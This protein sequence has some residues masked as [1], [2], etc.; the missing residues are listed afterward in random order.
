MSEH[1]RKRKRSVS[2]SSV[3]TST[4]V[5]VADM[6]YK[7]AKPEGLRQNKGLSVKTTGRETSSCLPV[8]STLDTKECSIPGEFEHVDRKHKRKELSLSTAFLSQQKVSP[9]DISA[10]NVTEKLEK[11]VENSRNDPYYTSGQGKHAP[12][13]LYVLQTHD[14]K[15]TY[16]GIANN[17]RRRMGSHNYC[18]THSNAYTA[19][20]GRPWSVVATVKGFETRDIAEQF[21]KLV[22]TYPCESLHHVSAVDNRVYR[23]LQ[24]C[25]ALIWDPL[26]IEV[27]SGVNLTCL[28][29]FPLP[30]YC[31]VERVKWMNPFNAYI[32]KLKRQGWLNMCKQEGWE[33]DGSPSG[34]KSSLKQ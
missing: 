2:P 32:H 20:R 12:V 22:K 18:E 14:K 27:D 17:L 26:L 4:S 19:Q 7:E 34:L 11:M 30:N 13:L 16:T 25:R 9:P 33:E 23:V 29:S 10:S 1:R 24:V 31:R 5:S 28:D 8:D 3:S 6:E 21:E 15:G